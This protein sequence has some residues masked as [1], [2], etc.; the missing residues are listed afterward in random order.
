MDDPPVGLE[1]TRNE[2]RRLLGEPTDTSIPT[3][4]QEQ[5]MIWKYGDIEYH[6]GDDDRVWLVYT[7]DAEGHPH[8]LGQLS[9]VR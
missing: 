3:R 6:F 7:E 5:P 1:A 8:V 2:L 9:S 4:G